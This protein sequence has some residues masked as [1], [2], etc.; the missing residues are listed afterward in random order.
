MILK[1]SHSQGHISK[2]LQCGKLPILGVSLTFSV[3]ENEAD[4]FKVIGDAQIR[5]L[6]QIINIEMCCNILF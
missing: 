6:T 1:I 5:Q 2:H 3:T 4:A